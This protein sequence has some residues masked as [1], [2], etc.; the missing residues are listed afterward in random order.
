MAEES[1]MYPAGDRPSKVI[2]ESTNLDAVFE[3]ILN[4][5]VK[6]KLPESDLPDTILILSDMQFNSCVRGGTQMDGIE[7]MYKDAGYKVPQ[8]VFWNLNYRGNV[9]VTYDNAN[10]AL[11]SGFSP[12]II[13]PIIEA[14]DLSPVKVMMKA[15]LNTRYNW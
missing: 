7:E 12:S 3:T 11:V 9:P 14:D 1:V 15:L 4:A 13:K 10:T 6:A 8:V 5:A 2:T